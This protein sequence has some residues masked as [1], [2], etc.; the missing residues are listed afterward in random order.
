MQEAAPCTKQSVSHGVTHG[1]ICVQHTLTTSSKGLFVVIAVTSAGI[2]L[3]PAFKFD[4][5]LMSI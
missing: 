4:V 1:G 5:F 2:K 3:S